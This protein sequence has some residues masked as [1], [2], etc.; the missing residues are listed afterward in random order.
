MVSPTES[1]LLPPMVY[2]SPFPLATHVEVTGKVSM[3]ALCP[4]MVRGI[5]AKLQIARRY[6][7]RTQFGFL[8]PTSTQNRWPAMATVPNDSALSAS[9]GSTYLGM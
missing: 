7:N 3:T 4:S 9:L 5:Y 2:A 8:G 1:R 6:I